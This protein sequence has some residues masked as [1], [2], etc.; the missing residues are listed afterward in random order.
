MKRY[1]VKTLFFAA[2]AALMSLGL[3][4]LLMAA[5][6]GVDG[7][8]MPGTIVI[9]NLSKQYRSVTFDHAMHTAIA[10]NCGMCHHQHNDKAR[11]TCSE[12]HALSADTFK[13]SVKQSFTACSACHSDPSSDMPEM[14]GLKV[15]L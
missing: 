2:C 6:A 10:G 8:E 1:T 14:P 4:A 7:K 3:L 12:C 5:P 9:K 11:A 15:A 13:A